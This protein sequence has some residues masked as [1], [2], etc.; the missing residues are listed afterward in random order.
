MVHSYIWVCYL[1]PNNLDFR[2]VTSSVLTVIHISIDEVRLEPPRHCM[3]PISKLYVPFLYPNCLALESQLVFSFSF[4]FL[5]IYT[6]L[7]PAN[8]PHI[9]V[10]Y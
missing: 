1:K 3:N 4:Y 10:T 9:I 2:I 5:A 7:R 8:L 6:F